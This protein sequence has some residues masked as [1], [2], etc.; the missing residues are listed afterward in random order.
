MNAAAKLSYQ[1]RMYGKW[2]WIFVD[3]QLLLQTVYCFVIGLDLQLLLQTVYCLVV[4]FALQ[5]LLRIDIGP[6]V[7][8]LN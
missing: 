4:G 3:L 1:L 6:L 5:L 8:A 7:K 2:K